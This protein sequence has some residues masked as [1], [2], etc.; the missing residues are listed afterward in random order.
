MIKSINTIISSGINSLVPPVAIITKQI[1][2]V[3]TGTGLTFASGLTFLDVQND[4][5]KDSIWVRLGSL[6]ASTDSD[7]AVR[8]N[9]QESLELFKHQLPLDTK[10]IVLSTFP[11]ITVPV[12]ILAGRE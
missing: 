4:D 7:V 6:V 8:I 11:G 2:A 3:D 9:A 1:T 10:D 12:R 5:K